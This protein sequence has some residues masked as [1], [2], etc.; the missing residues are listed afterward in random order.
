MSGGLTTAWYREPW[1]WALIAG[2]ALVVVAGAFT[3]FLA[4]RSDDGVVADDYY[5]QG[6]TINRVLHRQEKSQALAMAASVFFAADGRL[7]RVKVGGK[8]APAAELKLML[9]HATR[10]GRDQRI[11]LK[12]TSDGS[13]EG[14]LRPL[15]P[16]TW[17][18]VLEDDSAGW[19]LTGDCAADCA[20]LELR[21]GL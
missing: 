4:I 9:V 17:R 20:Q 5:R 2:P 3:V 10:S 12:K 18:V 7:V 13:F 21:S 1:V 8:A 6:L 15:A 14:Q 19:R 16:G 11:T